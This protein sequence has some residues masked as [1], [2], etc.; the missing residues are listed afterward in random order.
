M[1]NYK[2]QTLEHL[3]CEGKHHVIADVMKFRPELRDFYGNLPLF[4]SIK[5]DDAQMVA[6]FFKE[7][8]AKKY[9][10]LRN[11]K[12]QTIFHVAAQNNSLKAIEAVVGKSCFVEE[13]LKKDYK[14]DTPLHQAAK[15]GSLEILKWFLGFITPSF[16][17]MQNDFGQDVMTAVTDKMK[18]VLE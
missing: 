11:Y 15:S 13:L 7:N 5:V 4:V 14:G 9:Y 10:H 6:T 12:Y 3:A 1:Q 8:P 2:G 16:I 18:L 17:Q